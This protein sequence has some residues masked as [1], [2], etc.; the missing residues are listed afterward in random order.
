MKP[1]YHHKSSQTRQ[2][3]R[4]ADEAVISSSLLLVLGQQGTGKSHFGKLLVRK[5]EKGTSD[6]D[7]SDGFKWK[8]CRYSCL[9]RVDARTALC[10]LIELVDPESKASGDRISGL[11]AQFVK[12]VQTSDLSLLYLDNAHRIKAYDRDAIWEA[13]QKVREDRA[14]G[15][16][17]TSVDY[18]E[19][20]DMGLLPNVLATV[21]LKHLDI[22]ENL[23]GLKAHD[24]RFAPWIV[25]HKADDPEMIKWAERLKGATQGNFDRIRSLC[26]SLRTNVPGDTLSFEQVDKIL[27][28]WATRFVLD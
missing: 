6:D 1:L 7:K 18:G 21:V 14:F 23:H 3:L 15:V 13:V 11:I 19:F 28:Q 9:S 5:H 26:E 22:T 8:P 10:D 12:A 24:A 27:D 20:R 4:L 25:R 17:M 16:V 2:M